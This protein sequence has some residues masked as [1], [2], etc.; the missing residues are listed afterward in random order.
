MASNQAGTEAAGPAISPIDEVQSFFRHI[1]AKAMGQPEKRPTQEERSVDTAE[2]VEER[3]NKWVKD[4]AKGDSGRGKGRNQN[5]PK[6]SRQPDQ[7]RWQSWGSG[8]QSSWQKETEQLSE[9]VKLLARMT[10]RHEDELSQTRI[11]KEFILTLEVHGGGILPTMYQ[12]AQAWKESREKG[13]AFSS[14]R[15]TMLL[16][17][18]QEWLDRLE[19]VQEEQALAGALQLGICQKE[20]GQELEWLYLRW[21]PEAKKLIRD[22]QRDPVKHS[23]FM[24]WLKELQQGMAASQSLLRFHSTRPLAESYQGE[25]V[26]FLLTLG[27]RDPFMDR[28]HRLLGLMSGLGSTK[29][30]AFRIRPAKMER[31]PLARILEERFPPPN[32]GYPRRQ[33]RT[34]GQEWKNKDHDMD[35]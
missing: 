5:K 27:Y 16:A 4:N 12:V 10:L 24:E 32:R 9:A 23:V 22:T 28:A 18:I 1:S 31:Q 17:L 13:T 15:L 3:P 14:L 30:A 19:R 11:E 25:T 6:P 35:H 20:P 26:T 34:S 7:D 33:P 2:T 21:D 29:V 8:S